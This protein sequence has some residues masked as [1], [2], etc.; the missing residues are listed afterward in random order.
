MKSLGKKY[1]CHSAIELTIWANNAVNLL[2]PI[3]SDAPKLAVIK[4]EVAAQ[5][6]EARKD[7]SVWDFQQ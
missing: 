3:V 1:A 6:A 7:K 2:N 4:S 5:H